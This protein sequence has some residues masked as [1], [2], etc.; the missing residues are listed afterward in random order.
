M[1]DSCCSGK[2]NEIEILASKQAKALWIVL[3]INSVMFFA[4][5][6]LVYMW[7]TKIFPIKSK[8]H[9]LKLT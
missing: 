4:E 3:T 6:F 1:A 8:H 5:F 2:N 7:L 9:N